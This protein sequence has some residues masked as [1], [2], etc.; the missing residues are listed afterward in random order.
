MNILNTIINEVTEIIKCVGDIFVSSRFRYNLN[1]IKTYT[2]DTLYCNC[3]VIEKTLKTINQ[4]VVYFHSVKG[5]HLLATT[6]NT[7]LDVC[8]R[9]T[10]KQIMRKSNE[11]LW[12]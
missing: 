1:N 8:N 9:K 5:T 12:S 11:Y 6:F 10:E 2:L 7:S 4:A 3:S